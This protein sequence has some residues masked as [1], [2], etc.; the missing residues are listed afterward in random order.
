[1]GPRPAWAP[2]PISD[3]HSGG[4]VMWI[5]GDAIM[6]AI[7]MLVFLVWS[8]DG[9][10]SA[11]GGGW[12]EAAR[13]ASFTGLTGATVT[14]GTTGATGTGA[15]ATGAGQ[16]RQTVPATAATPGT[17]DSQPAQGGDGTIDDDEHLAAYNEFLARI[18]ASENRG[19]G[20]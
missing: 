2:N 10:V 14:T 8:R 19:R 6:F 3:L 7:M 1:M 13:R 16:P 18:N 20:R 4:A 11:S 5:G 17:P 12:L 15:G 9:R